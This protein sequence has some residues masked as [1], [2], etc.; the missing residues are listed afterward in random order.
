M[1]SSGLPHVFIMSSS[2]FHYV[3][4]MSSLCL[5]VFMRSSSCLHQVFISLDQVFTGLHQVFI[6]S[7]LCL[8]HVALTRCNR[9][10]LVITT[11]HATYA[12]CTPQSL[13]LSLFA[14]VLHQRVRLTRPLHVLA[15][16]G[17][18]SVLQNT[19]F[20][21][22]PCGPCDPCGPCG[23]CGCCWLLTKK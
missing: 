2:C 13:C 18:V 8:H 21:C 9:G 12:T 22:G 4:I 16:G 20:P 5:H 19:F 10:P 7:S 14:F 1:P 17:L 11:R 6:K 23:P 15:A 3:F